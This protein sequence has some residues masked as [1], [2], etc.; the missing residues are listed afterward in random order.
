MGPYL[1]RT[2]IFVGRQKMAAKNSIPNFQKEDDPLIRSSGLIEN[3]PGIVEQYFF[4]AEGEGHDFLI[5]KKF[6]GKQKYGPEKR[7]FPI[8]VIEI[9]KKKQIDVKY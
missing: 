8:K 2:G 3:F 9:A 4:A 7:L 1:K 6:P 5:P